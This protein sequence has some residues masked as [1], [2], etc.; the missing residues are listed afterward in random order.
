MNRVDATIATRRYALPRCPFEDQD[1]RV[2]RQVRCGQLLPQAQGRSW[3]GH[4]TTRPG[5][6]PPRSHRRR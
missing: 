4:A 1:D 3:A 5:D 2:V 6:C